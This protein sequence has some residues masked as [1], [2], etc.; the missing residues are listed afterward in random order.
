MQGVQS[1]FT[2]L[3]IQ[4]LSE[5]SFS[6]VSTGEQRLVLLARAL[7]KTPPLLILDEPCQGLDEENKERFKSLIDRV[8]R[9]SDQTLIYVTHYTDEI[10]DCVD[11]VLRLEKGR[12]LENVK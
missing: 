3:E 5:R 1:C 12:I 7:V 11:Q 9:H 8:C 6:A 4:H 2:W 10:P